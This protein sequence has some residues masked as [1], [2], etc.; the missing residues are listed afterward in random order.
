MTP[1]FQYAGRLERLFANLLDTLFLMAP[2][3]LLVKFFG[4]G[5]VSLVAGFLCYAAYYTFFTASDWQATPGKRLLNIFVIMRNGRKPDMTESFERFI[6]YLLPTLPL[7][8]SVLSPWMA[9]TLFVW[10]SIFWFAPILTTPERRGIH[11]TL[12]GTRVM[13]GR[14]GGTQ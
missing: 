12:V 11:D 3:L 9:Q 7:Y 14:A 4:D 8:T 13:A 1:R 6:V 5:G 2:N 10:M